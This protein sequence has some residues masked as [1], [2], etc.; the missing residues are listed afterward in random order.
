[1]SSRIVVLL[2]ISGLATT[3]AY[4]PLAPAADETK[5]DPQ[6]VKDLMPKLVT[7]KANEIVLSK[8]LKM[9]QDQTGIEVQ[10]PEDGDPTLK[11][12]NLDKVPFWQAL[13]TIAKNESAD[14]RVYPYGKER[15]V[16]LV[17]DPRGYRELPTSYSGPFRVVL[18][19]VVMV[20]DLEN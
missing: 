19:K 18:K 8:A 3:L 13:D 12:I 7:I 16:A 14:L 2:L 5:L 20:R 10:P 6:L 11:N 9:I 15:K 17:K 4:S 1:M